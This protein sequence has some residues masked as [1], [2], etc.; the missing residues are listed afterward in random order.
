MNP[1]SFMGSTINGARSYIDNFAAHSGATVDS[2]LFSAAQG[3]Y[4]IEDKAAAATAKANSMIS[5]A[6]QNV[7]DAR[8]YVGSTV[9]NTK[10]KINSTVTSAK[11]NVNDG[12][13]YVNSTIA[14]AKQAM[15]PE[16]IRTAKRFGGALLGGAAIMSIYDMLDD[17]Y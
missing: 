1:N 3:A 8:N 10:G 12:R 17:D 4:R 15:T 11:Q 7:N 2:V 6:K 9:T 16:R 5:S 14:S 13:N